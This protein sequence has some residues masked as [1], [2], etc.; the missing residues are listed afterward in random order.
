MSHNPN[1]WGMLSPQ[2]L[3]D[4]EEVPNLLG[5]V[6]L[7]FNEPLNFSAPDDV[8]GFMDGFADLK[9]K[10]T[11]DGDFNALYRMSASQEVLARLNDI[12]DTKFGKSRNNDQD[13]RSQIVRTHSLKSPEK[14]FE[15]MKYHH[16]Q[17]LD[18]L[19]RK[20]KER[21][22]EIP[23]DRKGTLYMIVGVK[24]CANASIERTSSATSDKQVKAKLPVREALAASGVPAG[25]ISAEPELLVK[26]NNAEAAQTSFTLTGERIFALQ[27]LL[28]KKVKEWR[29]M[30]MMSKPSEPV[31]VRGLAKM[32]RK[33]A[34]Y[35]AE[36]EPI[37]ETSRWEDMDDNEYGL[38]SSGP[39]ISLED[40]AHDSTRF[41]GFDSAETI[42]E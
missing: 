41:F 18:Y 39:D 20:S 38:G 16:A 34:L 8:K 40:Q 30:P 4:A 25:P 6:V 21:G 2:N 19:F 35:S 33:L 26:S 12:L 11:V 27:C 28:V 32:P 5:A 17:R 23:L 24:T 37:E 15:A 14:I 3:P 29:R 10:P 22:R 42:S 7:D 9:M 31:D 36:V 13:F 1:T